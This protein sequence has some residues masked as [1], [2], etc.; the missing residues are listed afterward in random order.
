MLEGQENNS[1]QNPP[2]VKP[3]KED[4]NV[5][6]KKEFIKREE[7]TTMERD[8]SKLR[9]AEAIEERERIASIKPEDNMQKIEE[10]AITGTKEIEK[11]EEPKVEEKTE[12]ASG[13]LIPKKIKKPSSAR[14]ILIRIISVLLLF[15]AIIFSYRLITERRL[16]E[17]EETPEEEQEEIPA[18]EETPEEIPVEPATTTEGETPAEE[19]P[20]EETPAEETP[21]EETPEEVTPV[22]EIPTTTGEK[23]EIVENMLSWG[24][25]TPSTPRTI[26]TIVLHSVYNAMGGDVHSLDGV[27]DEFEL[28]GVTSHFIISRD[29]TIYQLAP[30]EAIAYHAGRGQMPDGSRK[31]IINNFS[32]GIELIYTEEETPNETQIGKLIELV[33]YLQYKYD[34]SPDNIF[35]HEDISLSGKSDMWNYEK[36]EFIN[37]LN[38]N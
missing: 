18:E 36:E 27:V 29:G 5:E 20:A 26:D 19:T 10:K 4:F 30:E 14:K 13:I 6:K 15:L 12:E 35:E 34:I 38:N 7:I 21:I 16:I 33:S 25:Y 2:Q 32:I 23:P 3:P 22:E 24:Y 1:Y 31:N 17:Q 8:I 9:E 11:K 37:L 28:Y